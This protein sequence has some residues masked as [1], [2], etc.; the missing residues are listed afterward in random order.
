MRE[1]NIKIHPF[2]ELAITEY[3]GTK[4]INEHSY[5]RL[6]GEIPF[7][8]SEKYL[9][10]GKKK[11][12][13]H[14]TAVADDGKEKRLLC[15]MIDTMKMHVA[16]E[17]C[18]VELVIFSGTILMDCNKKIRSFQKNKLTYGELLDV[19]NR[20]YENADKHMAVAGK[21]IIKRFIMQYQETD[22]EFIKRLASMNHAVVVADD[23]FPGQKYC[24]GLPDNHS[25]IECDRV[26]YSIC[27]DM[28][29]YERKKGLGLDVSVDDT[30]SHVWESR[31]IYELGDCAIFN[32]RRLLVWKVETEMKGSVLYHTY[33]AKPRAGISTPMTYNANLSG[34]SLL[35]TVQGVSNEKVQIEIFDDE[36]KKKTGKRWFPFATV[37]SSQDGTGWYCMPETGDTI[38]LYFPTCKE[39]DAYVV[40][41]FHEGDAALR[42]NPAVKFWRNKEGKEIRLAP[43]KITVTNNQGTYIALS[44]EEGVEIVSSGSVNLSASGLLSISSRKSTIELSAPGRIKLRVVSSNL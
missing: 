38:R 7:S 12:W 14:I 41:A 6:A 25:D 29:E 28:E 22:W 37:Y 16:G 36:N 11:P 44:D 8:N 13:V 40:S 30:T 35:G 42:T 34:T 18:R 9:Q 31:E 27:L 19:C 39:Q 20:Q 32:G 23:A 33:Y 2:D 15:G 17:T 21:E 26:E 4:Q 24:F 3:Q 43:G 1:A 5:V 10:L